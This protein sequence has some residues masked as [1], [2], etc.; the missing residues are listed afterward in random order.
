MLAT[1]LL[2]L[3]HSNDN[4]VVSPL[5]RM[6]H[7]QHKN[8]IFQL[9]SLAAFWNSVLNT[10]DL[11]NQMLNCNLSCFVTWNSSVSINVHHHSP[12]I[13]HLAR[14][15][16]KVGGNKNQPEQNRTWKLL[17]T[18]IPILLTSACFPEIILKLYLEASAE[19]TKMQLQQNSALLL[20][21]DSTGLS[22][23][24]SQITC[25]S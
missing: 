12:V 16:I 11:I 3:C 19:R 20:S 25:P 23:T 1:I 24:V 13:Q 6:P 4:K 10:V 14:P 9:Y 2:L 8:S 18:K 5:V 7:F 22:V 15:K 21:A 17:P